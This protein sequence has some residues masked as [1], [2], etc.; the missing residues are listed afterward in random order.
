MKKNIIWLALIAMTLNSCVVSAE[1]IKPSKNY[2]TRKVNADKFDGISTAT[3]IDVVYTQTS[4]SQD[5]EIYA[6]DNLVDYVK[7]AVEDGTLK[8]RF[9]NPENPMKGISINGSHETEVRVSAPAVHSLQASSSGDVIL[10][11]G[12]QTTGQV[13]MKSSSSGDIEG[14][15]VVCEALKLSASSSG[16]VKLGKVECTDLEAEASSSGDVVLSAEC[17]T[18]RLEASS[19]GDVEIKHLKAETV[20][21][22]ASSSGDVILAGECRSAQFSASSSGGVQAKELV[23]DQVVA[24]ASSSGNVTCHVLESLDATASSSGSVNYKGDPKHIDFHPKKGL[25]KID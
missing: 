25:N 7:V 15:D 4:G 16:D 21:G 12:L 3:S 13:S 2:V 1:G 10:K 19:S 18:V 8:V 22:H 14:G 20:E 5:I 11:N 17:R 23:A 9:Y 24:K 6:P